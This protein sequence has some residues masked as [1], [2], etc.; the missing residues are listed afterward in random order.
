MFW[1]VLKITLSAC[2]IAFSSWL[3]GKKPELA[4]FI[5]ALPLTTLLALAF[6]FAE[7]HD[8]AVSVK[9]AKSI[10]AG[11][12]LSLLFFVPFLFAE[13]LQ[14]NFFALYALGLTLLVAGYFAHGYILKLL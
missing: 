11:V 9:Y 14:L 4:G 5:T 12:P 1:P 13:K 2:V 3:A 7:F 6:S 10:L 8:P